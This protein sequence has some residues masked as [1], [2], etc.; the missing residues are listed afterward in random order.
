MA[1]TARE[2]VARVSP[3]LAAQLGVA[4]GDELSVDCSA[5]WYTL[6]VAITPGMAKAPSGCRPTLPGP[7]WVNWAWSSATTSR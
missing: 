6:P 2:S 4:D 5:G 1:A 7:R 3:A